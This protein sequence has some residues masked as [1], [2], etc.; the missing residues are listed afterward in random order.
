MKVVS[1]SSYR[2]SA[3][4]KYFCPLVRV[5]N[6]LTL[7]MLGNLSCFCCHLLTFQNELFQNQL[8][9]NELFQIIISGTLIVSNALDPDIRSDV[10]SV[11]IW[12]QTVCK[13]YINEQQKSALARKVSTQNICIRSGFW[14]KIYFHPCKFPNHLRARIP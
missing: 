11:L 2:T 14:K 8:F 10:L 12:V 7:Y 3:I 5:I 1:Y 9:P 13:G 6:H 4:L